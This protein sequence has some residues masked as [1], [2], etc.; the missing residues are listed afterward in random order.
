MRREEGKD[1]K[2]REEKKRTL[3]GFTSSEFASHLF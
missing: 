1:A 3:L 2:A